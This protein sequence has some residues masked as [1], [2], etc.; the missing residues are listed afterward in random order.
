MA[1]AVFQHHDAVGAPVP[2]AD[3]FG[4]GLD[5]LG[6]FKPAVRLPLSTDRANAD[7]PVKVHR[8]LVPGSGAQCCAGAGLGRTLLVVRPETALD[9]GY[10]DP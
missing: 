4:A 3:E 2:D 5:P 6:Q 1:K 10:A 8:T 9:N 7:V